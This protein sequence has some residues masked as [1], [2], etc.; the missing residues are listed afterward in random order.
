[1]SDID[2]Y[3][4]SVMRNIHASA[5][6]RERIE[7]DL[8]SHLQEAT[9]EGEPA[10]NVIA[11]MGD[12]TQVAA[13]FM[14]EMPMRY[15]VFG[16]RV[17]AFGIDMLVIMAAAGVLALVAVGALNLLPRNP[18]G[19]DWVAGALLI[20]FGFSAG[21][22]CLG[23]FLLYFP[24]LEGRFGQTVGKRLLGIWVLQETGL[25]IGYKQALLRRLSYYF[26]IL[27]VDALF[28]PFTAKH[29]RAFDI[30]AHTVVIRE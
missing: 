7:S 13:E 11:R 23:I 6:Q 18:V 17:A 4:Q 29:Q 20:A 5:T 21:T 9:S 26:E 12:P 25:P 24:I 19:L 2:K 15:A 8:R 22:A 27:P 30:V 16:W 28:I 3:V 10:Q 1:M 14:A